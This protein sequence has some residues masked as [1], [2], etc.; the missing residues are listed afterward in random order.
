MHD[1]SPQPASFNPTEWSH[2]ELCDFDK[3]YSESVV[4]HYSFRLDTI[5]F[6]DLDVIRKWSGNLYCAGLRPQSYDERFI[7]P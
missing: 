4:G 3:F 2:F 5:L 1:P 6:I 7:T